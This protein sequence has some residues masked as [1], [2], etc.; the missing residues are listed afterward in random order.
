MQG[1][2]PQGISDPPGELGPDAQAKQP[3]GTVFDIMPPLSEML[4]RWDIM[5][6][7][8][9]EQAAQSRQQMQKVEAFVQAP[10]PWKGGPECS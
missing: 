7:V 5:R 2:V 8:P 4:Y 10:F 6:G 3:K 9:E 1:I